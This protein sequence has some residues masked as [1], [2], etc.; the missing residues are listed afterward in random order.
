MRR[1]LRYPWRGAAPVAQWIERRRPKAGVGGSNPSGGA[2]AAL[3]RGA[4]SHSVSCA[5]DAEHSSRHPSERREPLDRYE[6]RERRGLRNAKVAA[7]A[8]AIAFYAVIVVGLIKI[9]M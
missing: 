6:R 9:F 1:I 8:F 5:R 3:R 2:I 7:I 4:K